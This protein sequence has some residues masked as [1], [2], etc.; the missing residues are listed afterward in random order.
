MTE[1][2]NKWTWIKYPRIFCP[3]IFL[4]WTALPTII[5]LP[6]AL[7]WLLTACSQTSSTT[8]ETAAAPGIRPGMGMGMGRQSGMM[9]RHSAPIPEAYAGLKNPVT[10]DDASLDR[11]AE[12]YATHCASCHGD[13]AMGDGPAAADL[14]PAPVP[15]AHTSQMM[16]D[17]YLFWRVSEG[18]ALD[19][20]NSTMPPWK[21]VLDEQ[22]R[23]DVINYM[24]AL[25]SGTVPMRRGMGG[26]A[27]D[28]DAQA[29]REAEMVATAVAQGVL[30][31][32]EADVF[33]QVHAA[34]EGLRAQG[35]TGTGDTASDMQTQM[36]AEL[37][38]LGTIT[39]PEADAFSD[40]HSRMLA[41]GLMD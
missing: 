35:F 6:L 26:A 10:A 22:A 11:G 37:M 19:P 20:F 24:R 25:G 14:D 1:F 27:F 4:R 18:G 5:L 3:R 41:A 33:N 15:I 28:P 2:L 40:A 23:W 21:G 34:V 30:T 8:E 9:A 31:Q 39:Q 12:L 7:I 13:G 32:A 38:R 16:S 29:T 17:S 36:L